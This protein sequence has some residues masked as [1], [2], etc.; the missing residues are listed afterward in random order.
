MVVL[1]LFNQR[2]IF[3]QRHKSNLKEFGERITLTLLTSWD[4]YTYEEDEPEE[5][6]I[7]QEELLNHLNGLGEPEEPDGIRY[8]VGGI[9]YTF[10]DENQL[11]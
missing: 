4:D 7:E 5:E 10:E 2:F 8:F 1:S 11:P 3:A 6:T 9:E